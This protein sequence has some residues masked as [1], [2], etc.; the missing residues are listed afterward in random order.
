MNLLVEIGFNRAVE[1]KKLDETRTI[2][3]KSV[4][5]FHAN[6]AIR[7]ERLGKMLSLNFSETS[8]RKRNERTCRRNFEIAKVI[9]RKRDEVSTNE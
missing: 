5:S 9:M 1:K 2:N 3:N 7:R 8:E 4:V 6:V